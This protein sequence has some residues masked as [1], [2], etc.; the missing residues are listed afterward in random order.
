MFSYAGGIIGFMCG[1]IFDRI[2]ANRHVVVEDPDQL[3]ESQAERARK[4]FFK[5][6]FCVM[7]YVAK[8][9]GSVKPEQIKHTEKVMKQMGLNDELRDDAK[10]YFMLGKQSDFNISKQVKQ[11]RKE[12]AGNTELFRMLLEA[13]V[14]VALADGVMAVEEERVLLRVTSLLGFPETVYR[15]IEVLVRISMGLGDDHSRRYSKRTK[16]QKT[17]RNKPLSQVDSAYILLAVSPSDDQ[18]TITKAYR[19]LMSQ[20][21]PDKLIAQGMPE[22]G[23]KLA[24][25]KTQEIR[26]A[27]EQIKRLKGWT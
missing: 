4:S 1:H 22:E 27:F 12:C 16:G 26:K 25:N 20:H 17:T 21:H 6:M 23:L 8:I 5:T 15:Q 19:K 2:L 24:T 7:G 10:A 14:Q 13:Q 9:D 11:F 18:E 3:A